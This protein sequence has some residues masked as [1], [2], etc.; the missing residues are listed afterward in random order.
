MPPLPGCLPTPCP[1]HVQ[2]RR[3]QHMDI[4]QDGTEQPPKPNSKH[5]HVDKFPAWTAHVRGFEGW[6]T[7]ANFR[8]HANKLMKYLEED[9]KDFLEDW[10]VC[11]IYDPP[12]ELFN[13]YNEVLYSAEAGHKKRHRK[14]KQE[15]LVA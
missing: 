13:R 3:R 12:T 11:S 8:K 10:F 9:D 6:P 14:R 2:R 4:Y 5:V 7:A 1:P 15:G